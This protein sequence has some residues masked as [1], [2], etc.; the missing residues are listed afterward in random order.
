MFFFYQK[1]YTNYIHVE[2]LR[3]SESLHDVYLNFPRADSYTQSYF[4][5]NAHILNDE[6]AIFSILFF[7]LFFSI[8]SSLSKFSMFDLLLFH[9]LLRYII[10][11]FV[12]MS[13]L[14]KVCFPIFFYQAT[15][16]CINQ[17]EK[18]KTWKIQHFVILNVSIISLLLPSC[19]LLSIIY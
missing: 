5:F 9:T 3:V 2:M 1:K 11:R 13:I 4:S 16:T 14:I 15:K 12:T 17:D 6:W 7:S 10:W 8:F 19:I 18:T